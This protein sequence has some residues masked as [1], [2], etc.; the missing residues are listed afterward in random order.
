MNRADQGSHG[1]LSA[2]PWLPSSLCRVDPCRTCVQQGLALEPDSVSGVSYRVI[3]GSKT[4]RVK[5]FRD[6]RSVVAEAITDLLK[7]DPEAVARDAMATNQV[8][9][10]GAAEYSLIAHGS[11]STTVT[12]RGEPVRMAI[13]KKR[14]W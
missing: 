1:P 13:I 14:W 12:V 5:N 6:A 11:W 7:Q 4:V 9:D 2:G 3:V 10:T 8:F